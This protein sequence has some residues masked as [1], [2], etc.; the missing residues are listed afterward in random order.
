MNERL[1]ELEYLISRLMEKN[2]N[3]ERRIDEL[4]E[5]LKQLKQKDEP[6]EKR[7]KKIDKL[8]IGDIY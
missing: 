8:L 2:D 1:N 3:L 7:N 5:N 6:P 4:E